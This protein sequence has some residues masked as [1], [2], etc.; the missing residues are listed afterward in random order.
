LG[1]FCDNYLEIVK[2][3]FWRPEVYGQPSRRAAQCTLDASFRVIVALAAPFMPFVTEE[4]YARLYAAREA[5]PSIHV[6]AWP[7]SQATWRDPE[8]VERLLPVLHTL[9]AWRYV[10]THTK[11][12]AGSRVARII[13]DVPES[14]RTALTD[15]LGPLRSAL[16]CE[17]ICFGEG[18]YETG[19]QDWRVAVVLANGPVATQETVA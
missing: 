2:D 5:L 1:T 19:R 15:Q 12:P 3:R 16:R 6:S 11:F 18:E 17:Q 13:L 8:A 7:E 4:I 10:R 14:V 9:D